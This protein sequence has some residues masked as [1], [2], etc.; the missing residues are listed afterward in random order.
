[1]AGNKNMSN[2]NMSTRQ[3][4]L[5]VVMVVLGAYLFYTERNRGVDRRDWLVALG[6]LLMVVGALYTF[7]VFFGSIILVDEILDWFK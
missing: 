4:L 1:M 2:M 3:V 6:A 5:G 7:G